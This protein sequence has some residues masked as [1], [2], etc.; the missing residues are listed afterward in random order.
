MNYL[1]GGVGGVGGTGVGGVVILLMLLL[2]LLLLKLLLLFVGNGV[3]IN[4]SVVTAV[5][6]FVAVVVCW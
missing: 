6:V 3:Y 5:S 2:L 4:V 1:G